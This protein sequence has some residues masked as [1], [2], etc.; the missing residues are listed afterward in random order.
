MKNLIIVF[1]ICLGIVLLNGCNGQR[2]KWNEKA[3]KS[4]E[5]RCQILNPD[6]T[7][8]NFVPSK[9]CGH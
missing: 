5:G 2:Y 7:L 9:K 8:G 3:G 4:G 1:Y 6:G